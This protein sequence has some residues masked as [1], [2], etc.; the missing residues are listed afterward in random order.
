VRS[1]ALWAGGG[2][3]VDAVSGGYHMPSLASHHPG[4]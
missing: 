1:L 4:P 3:G 2:G